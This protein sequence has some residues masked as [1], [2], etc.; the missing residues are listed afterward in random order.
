[1]DYAAPP[2]SW[3]ERAIV[4]L[5]DTDTYQR[6]MPDGGAVYET[7]PVPTWDA[8][9]TW[10]V[11]GIGDLQRSGPGPRSVTGARPPRI[12]CIVDWPQAAPHWVDGDAVEKTWPA[13]PGLP[14][15]AV[16]TDL[17]GN[18]RDRVIAYYRALS[19]ALEQ[20]AFSAKAPADAPVACTAARATRDALIPAAPYAN[21]APFYAAPLHDIDD[22]IAANCGKR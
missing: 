4:Q 13:R 9:R 20:G 5:K 16:P 3:V 10:L 6:S 22:W 14:T 19:T 11:V 7:L 8:Q 15:P 18:H 2:L 21:L 12:A 1:M 17:R